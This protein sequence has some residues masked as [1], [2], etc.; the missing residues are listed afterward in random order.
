MNTNRTVLFLDGT[1]ARLPVFV[2][3]G[4]CLDGDPT[5]YVYRNG[6]MTWV[7]PGESVEFIE[8]K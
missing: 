3:A 7:I 5:A 8:V 1:M 2:Y 6:K 4:A